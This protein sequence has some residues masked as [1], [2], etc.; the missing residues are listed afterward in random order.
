MGKIYHTSAQGRHFRRRKIPH[1]MQLRVR[2]VCLSLT[3]FFKTGV[4]TTGL[5]FFL[6]AGIFSS[7]RPKIPIQP[8]YR[9][10]PWNSW[11][12]HCS[13]HCGIN[14]SQGIGS[15]ESISRSIKVEKFRL[16][17]YCRCITV[18]WPYCNSLRGVTLQVDLKMPGGIWFTAPLWLKISKELNNQHQMFCLHIYI[19]EGLSTLSAVCLTLLCWFGFFA[20]FHYLSLILA[21]RQYIS[22]I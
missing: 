17:T 8:K 11:G 21:R 20:D 18:S 13:F 19:I 16:S 9:K 3:R 6:S 7:S 10:Y 12:I 1:L 15:M 2:K 4:F 5:N 22:N 14:F